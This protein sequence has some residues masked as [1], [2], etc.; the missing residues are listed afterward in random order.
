MSWR[1]QS[2][3]GVPEGAL[4]RGLYR[5]MGYT[6][7]DFQKPVIAIVNTW[8]TICPGHFN[9]KLVA[10][11]VK[12]GIASN[13]GMPVEFGS[14]GPCDGIAQGHE[15]MTYILPSREVIVQSVEVM[16]QAH[17]LDGMVLL[18]SCDKT[19]PALL[20]AAARLDLP[21]IV[22]NGGPMEP[23]DRH[24]RDID[25]NEIE[26]AVGEYQAGKIDLD[27]LTYVEKSACPTPG[28]CTMLGTAN[29][30]SCLA[31]A[32]GMSLPGSAT[33]P[34]T[35]AKRLEVARESGRRAVDLVREGISA[36]TILSPKAL[37]NAMRVGIA[38]G[39]S[40]NQV[41]HLLALAEE[42]EIPLQIE[43]FD[44][45]S[46]ET[47][48]IAWVMTAS[49]Y[50][51]VDF[52]RAGGIPAVMRQLLP[53]LH[54]DIVTVSGKSV[55]ENIGE[56]KIY[57]EKVIRP[58]DNPFKPDGGLA[59]LKGNLAPESA[60]A[61]PSAIPAH[62]LKV[63]GS[64]RVFDSEKDLIAAIKE[65]KILP[66]DIL[67]VRYEGPKGG[68]G[69]R[70]MFSPLKLLDGYGLADQV[71]LITDGRFS[72]SNRGGFVGHICPEA[73]VGGPLAFVQN[74]DRIL[75]DIPNRRLDLLVSEAE[76]AARQAD[77]QPP[78]K[79]NTKGYLGLY[80]QLVQSAH[81]GAVL[82][83]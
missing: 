81:R 29:T 16:V 64:A 83:F 36:R 40:T 75:V 24:G 26:V 30:M 4:A 34:A 72:G 2:L 43:E 48:Y 38:I 47:P 70:E 28:S 80:S 78:A 31:E 6:D 46:Q 8:N 74:G 39:G 7:E 27:E 23:G 54:G 9:L 44:R 13:G 45:L 77:W 50:D 3:L 65:D 10:E 82:R 53:K 32:L 1:S 37:E 71:Y 14:I 60:V 62:R 76:I 63:E 15:G 35:S 17:R 20:M 25:V 33:V 49:P 19:V 42:A 22:V 18:G 68:P 5:S 52:H 59:I 12:E 58:L 11:A 51:M 56:A 41:L 67:V 73:A 79:K 69:M 66:G 21:A 61:K 57:D 55:A